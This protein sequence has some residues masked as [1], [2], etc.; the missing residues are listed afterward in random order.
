LNFTYENCRGALSRQFFIFLPKYFELKYLQILVTVQVG[1]RIYCADRMKK[2]WL[3]AS[4][5]SRSDFK[6]LDA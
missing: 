2:Q 3:Q 1:L 5:P 6:W 4:S